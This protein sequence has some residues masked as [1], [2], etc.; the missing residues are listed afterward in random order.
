MVKPDPAASQH[1]CGISGTEGWRAA[2]PRNIVAQ[3]K[4]LRN[5]QM[6]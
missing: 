4:N 5:L 1:S 2:P 3:K 6:D